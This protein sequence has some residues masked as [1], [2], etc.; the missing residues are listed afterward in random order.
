MNKTGKGSALIILAIIIGILL[1][2]G[3]IG[4][5][6]AQKTGITC[7]MGIGETLCWTWHTNTL[8][9]VQEFFEDTGDSI[10]DSFDN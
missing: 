10:K 5:Q 8:G 4:G 6:Q 9:Q 7:D 1:V 2:W 3:F